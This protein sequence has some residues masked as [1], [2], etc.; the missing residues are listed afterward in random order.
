MIEEW[1]RGQ[2]EQAG[3]YEGEDKKEHEK[4]GEEKE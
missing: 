3:G 2:K 1:E 4:E